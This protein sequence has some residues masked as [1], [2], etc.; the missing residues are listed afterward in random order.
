MM[1]LNSTNIM[2]CIYII[3]VVDTFLHDKNKKFDV[4]EVR[5][6]IAYSNISTYMLTLTST[7]K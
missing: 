7:L 4:Y 1:V 3:S 5:Q 6:N 2:F